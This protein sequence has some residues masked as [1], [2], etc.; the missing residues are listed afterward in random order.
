MSC[1][2]TGGTGF[3]GSRVARRLT[4]AGEKVV[5]YDINPQ[6]LEGLA[7]ELVQ[8]DVLDLPHLLRTARQHQADRIVHLAYILGRATEFNPHQAT[9]INVEG[10]NNVFEVASSLGIKR[11]VWASSIAVFGPKSAGP[12]GVVAND[13]PYHP[14]TI[15]GACKVVNELT[16]QRYARSFG[17]EPIGLRFPAVYGPGSPRGWAG[18][19]DQIARD[20]AAGRMARVPRGD[21]PQ[22][23]V[24]VEDIA[25][26]IVLA[27][28]V[29][30]PRHLAFTLAGEV[31]TTTQVI[32]I[33]W[34]LCPD[35]PVER[36]ES[37]PE[38]RLMAHLDD[39]PAR[40]E[41]GWGLGHSLEA[42]L[43]ATIN[44]HRQE[45]GQPPL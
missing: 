18:F 16:A 42:G 34:H 32:D 27:L 4:A 21:Q 8:G 20:L 9:K 22:N 11:V 41:L 45:R 5:A 33:M 36:M 31:A 39:S 43:R 40:Q 35:A 38:A 29:P 25:Q 44:Y 37:F 23:W 6:D 24:Y 2:I 14:A 30:R 19:I 15:Y 26:A 10:T 28:G 17:L 1:L 3:I 7:A 12:D 13:A